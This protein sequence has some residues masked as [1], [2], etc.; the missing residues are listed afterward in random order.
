MNKQ[1]LKTAM[2]GSVACATLLMGSSLV[3]AASYSATQDTYIY[4]FFGN[5]GAGAGDSNGINVWNHE[6][7][8]GAQGLVRFDSA[9]AGDAAILS[10]NYT[11][12]LN[13]FSYCETGGFV[14]ACAGE[15]AAVTTDVVLQGSA[16]LEDDGA[17][18]WGDVSQASSPSASFTQATVGEGWISLD[19]TDLVNS[20]VLGG[21]ADNGLALTQEAYGVVRNASNSLTVSQFCDSE[22]TNAACAAGGLSPYLEINAPAAVPVPGAAWLFG[23]ALVGLTGIGRNRKAK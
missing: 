17:L 10:G 15:A 5:Q 22:S 23:S 16:W 8:H 2:A 14:G 1:F 20:W 13:I 21:V 12:T 11:A 6:S 9:W 18:G 19:I 7:N 3:Q 4:E